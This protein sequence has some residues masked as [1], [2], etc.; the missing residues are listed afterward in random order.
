MTYYIGPNGDDTAGDGSSGNPWKTV[1]KFLSVIGSVYIPQAYTAT[2]YVQDGHYAA[3]GEIDYW[4]PCGAR[5]QILG[6]NTYDITMSSVQSTTAIGGGYT[7]VLNVSDVSNVAVNDYVVI[8]I[9]SGGTKPLML[10]G[11]HQVTNVDAVNKRITLQVWSF[12]G[13]VPSGAVTGY[14]RVLKSVLTFSGDGFHLGADLTLGKLALVGVRN[15]ATSAVMVGLMGS[16]WLGSS[17]TVL[18]QSL[19]INNF[20]YGVRVWHGY[21]STDQWL[22]ISGCG[23]EGSGAG[24]YASGG[25]SH[26]DAPFTAIGGAYTG[27]L[28]RN[29]GFIDITGGSLVGSG[30]GY[31]ASAYVGG[32]CRVTSVNF[33]SNTTNTNPALNTVGNENALVTNYASAEY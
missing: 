26:I 25:G 1:G 22:G 33:Q 13:D 28:A 9:P 10:C 3:V 14:I 12:S 7:V 30:V 19:G 6:V 21:A 23:G 2:L 31:G 29:C 32:L 4:H 24:L 20:D 27:A 16:S 18:L 8:R 5:V 17:P 11:C 15:T